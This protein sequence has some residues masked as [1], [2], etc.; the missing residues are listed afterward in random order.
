MDPREQLLNTLMR[1]LEDF[2]L[3]ERFGEDKKAQVMKGRKGQA[4]IDAGRRAISDNED[5]YQRALTQR[6]KLQERIGTLQTEIGVAKKQAAAESP[7]EQGRQIALFG[8]PAVA[9]AAAG[10]LKGNS[11]SKALRER[12]KERSSGISGLAQSV[13]DREIP[14]TEAAKTARSLRLMGPTRHG[15]GPLAFGAG[16]L[17]AGAATRAFAPDLTDNPIGQDV[18]RA[19]G[20]LES[21]V[22]MG[23][24]AQ[25]IGSMAGGVTQPNPKDIAMIGGG[26]ASPAPTQPPAKPA[27]NS[28]TRAA[29]YQEAKARG[30]EVTTRT[31]KAE[32][33]SKLAA[34]MKKAS[35]AAKKAPKAIVPAAVGIGV[36]DALRNPAEAADGAAQEP[37]SAGGAAL[38]GGGAAAATGGVIAGGKAL[39]SRLSSGPLGA[40]LRG[41]GR[42]AGPAGVAMGAYDLANIVIDENARGDTLLQGPDTG[43]MPETPGNPNFLARQQQAARMGRGEPAL[44]NA[45]ALEIPQMGDDGALDGLAA[46]AEQDPELAEMLKAII[47]ERTAGQGDPM[48]TALRSYSQR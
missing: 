6:D 22:G 14:H 19:I 42:V 5:Q 7:Y 24:T 35:R 21:G 11:L 40:A 27:P 34:A 12:A 32:L 29:L 16:S 43:A 45:A 30:L 18:I 10:Y 44:P 46:A 20:G 38:A 39:A 4:D 31:K 36:Y 2:Q 23:L 9:G 3:P 17:A 33:E 1:D 47:L 41:V 37:M 13:R 26:P 28:G 48:A 15:L 8:A 25:Q